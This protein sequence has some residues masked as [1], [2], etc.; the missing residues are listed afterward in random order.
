[1]N[2][3]PSLVV[4]LLRTA[5]VLGFLGVSLGAF[6][7]HGLA[8]VLATHGTT[9]IWG[10]A[11]QYHFIHTLA[12]LALATAA[13]GALGKEGTWRFLGGI[14]W[15]WSLGIVVFSGSLYI[16]SLTGLRWLGAITPIGGLLFL[17][18]WLLLFFSYRRA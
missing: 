14:G 10:T 4:R 17:I 2:T 9:A 18:G 15:C 8:E 6:G 1:M 12:L 5:A 16:L 11:V 3:P 13:S 7:A